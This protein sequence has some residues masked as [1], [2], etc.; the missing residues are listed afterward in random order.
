[1]LRKFMRPESSRGLS[2][3]NLLVNK[4]TKHCFGDPCSFFLRMEIPERQ[5]GKRD[6]M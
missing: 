5:K 6:K 1:M 3:P 2:L 4:V